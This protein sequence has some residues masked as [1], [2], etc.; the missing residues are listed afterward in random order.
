M[1]L[2]NTRLDPHLKVLKHN[3]EKIIYKGP[4]G[5]EEAF[6]FFFFWQAEG[7]LSLDLNIAFLS[8]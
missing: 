2:P 1:Q 6:F 8:A 7:I 4:A 5:N 3:E